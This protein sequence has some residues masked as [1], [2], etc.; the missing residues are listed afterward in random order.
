MTDKVSEE[1]EKA[2]GRVQKPNPF[3]LESNYDIDIDCFL[4]VS[5]DKVNEEVKFQVEMP[6]DTTLAITFGN[7]QTSCDMIFFDSKIDSPTMTDCFYE[8]DRSEFHQVDRS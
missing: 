5:W 6:A 4:K 2:D 7:S 8:P 1:N 3:S